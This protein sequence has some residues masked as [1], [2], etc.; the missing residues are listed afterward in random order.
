V[1]RE[2]EESFFRHRD[3]VAVEIYKGD[4]ILALDDLSKCLD[5]IY[6]P[7]WR[8]THPDH[9]WTEDEDQEAVA[10]AKTAEKEVRDKV[11][12]VAVAQRAFPPR[13]KASELYI[14]VDRGKLTKPC[15]VRTS[16]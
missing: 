4:V 13:G 9:E 8:W 2:L 3:V 7:R 15:W 6:T 12:R 5:A 16:F 10:K 11:R 1:I 14:P